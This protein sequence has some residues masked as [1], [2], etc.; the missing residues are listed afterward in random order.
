MEDNNKR[1][2]V[3]DTWWKTTAWKE[4]IR[5]V[6]HGIGKTEREGSYVAKVAEN[7]LGKHGVTLGHQEVGLC[8]DV[9]CDGTMHH[10]EGFCNLASDACE[11]PDANSL[12]ADVVL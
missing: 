8:Q 12:V 10:G 1:S 9:E 3:G 11:A 2:A 5:D 7:A 4:S 6:T